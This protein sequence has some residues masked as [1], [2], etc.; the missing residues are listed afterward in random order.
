MNN[1][2]NKN[3][4]V[5]GGS[6]GIGRAVCLELAKQGANVLVNFA[7]NEAA[8]LQT[9]SECEALGVKA[10]AV[11]ADVSAAD[12]CEALFKRA[13]EEFASIDI[14]VNNAGIVRDALLMRATEEDYD[15]VM[16]INLKS[17]FLCTK[18]ASR[19]MLKQRSG[20]IINMGSVVGLH[21]NVGQAVY[22][23]SKAGLVGFTKT[24]AKELGS[25]GVTANV[26]APGF[27]E[28][29]MT[30]ALAPEIQEK[31]LSHIPLARLGSSEEV[32]KT[33][34]FLAGDA[35]AYITGQVISIDGG[36]SM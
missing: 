11:K 18:I 6:R 4:I 34:C 17:A 22:S 32:A 21:G 29:D 20:R 36:M 33:V 28:T 31:I 23:A 25:R 2:K 19:I 35:G 15:A 10:F 30:A 9:V 1:L 13:A 7:G 27:I 16:N 14:L 5:T 26:V 3:A 8:A 12:D 24:V